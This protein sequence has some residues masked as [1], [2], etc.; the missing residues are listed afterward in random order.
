MGGRRREEMKGGE[1]ESDLKRGHVRVLNT[2][3]RSHSCSVCVNEKWASALEQTQV[4]SNA[5]PHL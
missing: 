3:D 2:C 1:G 4:S 5:D